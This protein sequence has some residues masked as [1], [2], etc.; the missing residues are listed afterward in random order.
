VESTTPRGRSRNRWQ[1]EVREDERIVG[2]GEWQEKVYSREEWKKLLIM[3]RNRRI[4]HM[5][6]EWMNESHE[7]KNSSLLGRC[8]A[9]SYFLTL[10]KWSVFKFRVQQFKKNIPA[11]VQGVLYWCGWWNDR[12]GCDM[13]WAVSGC[14]SKDQ[15]MVT[16]CTV[17]SALTPV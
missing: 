15:C 13:H 1:D 2:G 10:T 14:N 16:L 11:V 12:G 6:M 4:L 7:F 5:Q 9:S 3:A 8:C 17:L